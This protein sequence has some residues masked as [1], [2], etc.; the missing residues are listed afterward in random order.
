MVVVLVE[1]A[2]TP[3][4]ARE[5]AAVFRVNERTANMGLIVAESLI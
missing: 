4:V 2:R 5:A 1:I 3:A